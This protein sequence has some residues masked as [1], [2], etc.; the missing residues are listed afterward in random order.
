MLCL[1]CAIVIVTADKIQEKRKKKRLL[2]D[3]AL[4]KE[5]EEA[6][7]PPPAYEHIE[8]RPPAFS[9]SS[10]KALVRLSSSVLIYIY[11]ANAVC[12]LDPTAL[13]SIRCYKPAEG[14]STV[15]LP[16]ISR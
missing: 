9:A 6:S 11:C 1:L 2:K 4:A 13:S 3:A 15:R 8:G 7:A 10:E 16:P 5:K 12:L 14:F